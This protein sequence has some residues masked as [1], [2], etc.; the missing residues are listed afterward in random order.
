MLLEKGD[1]VLGV[2]MV[3]VKLMCDEDVVWKFA[4]EVFAHGWS[5]LVGAILVF[6]GCACE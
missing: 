3:E 5:E 1:V 4:Y 6:E 2:S